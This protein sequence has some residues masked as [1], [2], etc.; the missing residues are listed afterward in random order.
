MSYQ[1]RRWTDEWLRA[2]PEEELRAAVAVMFAG[3]GEASGIERKR[4][5]R[6]VAELDRRAN[7]VNLSTR[8]ELIEKTLPVVNEL[9]PGATPIGAYCLGAIC[10]LAWRDN[11]EL[12]PHVLR[13]GGEMLSDSG[14]G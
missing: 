3:K 4:Y 7:L 12:P 9:L 13:V 14:G 5:H 11:V 6:A 10:T 2:I 8:E 1:A